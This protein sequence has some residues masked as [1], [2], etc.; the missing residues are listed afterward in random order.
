[1]KPKKLSKS[2]T[3][4]ETIEGESGD[5]GGRVVQLDVEDCFEELLHQQSF[6]IKNQLERASKAPYLVLFACSS[7]V[8]YGIRF[9]QHSDQ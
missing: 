9:K 5:V 7:L 8:L 2:L 6:A 3:R 4:K 1:M